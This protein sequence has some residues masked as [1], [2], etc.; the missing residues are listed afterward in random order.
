MEERPERGEVFV[1]DVEGFGF[2]S[3]GGAW[4]DK[5]ERKF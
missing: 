1:R 3:G 2:G 5:M 4:F